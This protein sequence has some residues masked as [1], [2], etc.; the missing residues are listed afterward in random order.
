M[1]QLRCVD[2][3]VRDKPDYRGT[4]GTELITQR[5]RCT[6]SAG[7]HRTQPW[8]SSS[9]KRLED[10]TGVTAKPVVVYSTNSGPFRVKLSGSIRGR[11]NSNTL[12]AQKKTGNNRNCPDL[13]SANP[14]VVGSSPTTAP[15]GKRRENLDLDPRTHDDR[16]VGGQ[17]EVIGGVPGDGKSW[18][19]R[20]K[21]RS[22][23]DW[24]GIQSGLFIERPSTG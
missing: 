4:R 6:C 8:P 12:V 13:R 23:L 24:L 9:R 19:I 15:P 7:T 2:L 18:R 22:R 5:F 21:M 16:A 17:A 3:H 14:S 1:G 10:P 11:W 20:T